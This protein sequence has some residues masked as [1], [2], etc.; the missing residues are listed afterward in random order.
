MPRQVVTIKVTF[1]ERIETLDWLDEFLEEN[2]LDDDAEVDQVALAEFALK[3]FGEE[4]EEGEREFDNM[5][6][7]TIDEVSA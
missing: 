4:L 7:A 5:D 1:H 6:D 2:E 3:K